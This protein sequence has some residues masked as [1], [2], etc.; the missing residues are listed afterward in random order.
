MAEE[1]CC[2]RLE[3]GDEGDGRVRRDEGEE[4]KIEESGGWRKKLVDNAA[5]KKY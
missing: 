5:T 1:M 2:G 3:K 4:R